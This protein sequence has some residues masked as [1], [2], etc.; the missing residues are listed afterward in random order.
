MF[1]ISSGKNKVN[2]P[3]TI[4]IPYFVAFISIL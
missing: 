4:F 2:F 3:F 1:A